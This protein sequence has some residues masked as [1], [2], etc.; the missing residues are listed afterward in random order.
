[1]TLIIICILCNLCV[2][3][4]IHEHICIMYTLECF[5]SNVTEI[6]NVYYSFCISQY[7]ICHGGGNNA[8]VGM[9]QCSFLLFVL[10]F[11]IICFFYNNYKTKRP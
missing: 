6:P 11:C 3:V 1:M 8:F 9:A 2:C 4:C 10:H 7:Q 5:L